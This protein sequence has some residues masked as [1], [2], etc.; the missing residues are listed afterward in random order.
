M[1]GLT[2]GLAHAD[3]IAGQGSTAAIP[4][5]NNPVAVSWTQTGAYSNVTV[6]ADLISAGTGTATVYLT[7]H[8]GPGTTTAD[9]L[10]VATET[11]SFQPASETTLFTGLSLG[12]GTYYVTLFSTSISNPVNFEVNLT[13]DS[14]ATPGNTTNTGLFAISSSSYPPATSFFNSTDFFPIY[15]VTGTPASTSTTPEPSSLLLLG[16]GLL[17][18]AGAVKRRLS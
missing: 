17:G 8:I 10:A 18:F 3:V 4:L 12:P 14:L 16:T 11:M 7:D 6:M 2:A 5:G 9:Q 13:L 15:E 1:S